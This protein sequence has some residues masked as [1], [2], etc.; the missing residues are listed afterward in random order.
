MTEKRAG[1]AVV[2]GGPAGL[3]AAWRLS[4]LGCGVR[5][6]EA[7]PR[8]G[9][10]LRTEEVAGRGADAVVQLLSDGYTDTRRLVGAMGLADRLMGVAGRDALWRNGRPHALRYGSVTSMVAS[11]A[12]STGLKVRLGLRYMPF[13]ERHAD[14][15]DLNEPARAVEAG[16]DDV[17]IADWG[18]E[19]LGEE[20][21]ETLAYPLLAAYYGVTPEETSAAFFHS[22]AKAGM[23]VEVVGVRGGFGGLAAAMA[24]ALAERG[25]EIRTG[26]PVTAIDA[27]AAGARVVVEEGSVTHDAA[28]LAVPPGV[29]ARLVPAVPLPGGIR[30]RSTATLILSTG[31]RLGTGWF[32]LS[33]PRTEP[34]GDVLAAVCVQGEKET[35]V[36]GGA[37]E[38]L[39][40]VPAPEAGERWA[41]ADAGS[42]VAEGI[43]ALR[44][45]LPAGAD[46]VEEARL[47][48]LPDAVWLPERGH[49]ERLATFRPESLPDRLALAGDYLV[50]PT[51]EGAVRSGLAAAERIAVTAAGA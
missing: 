4:E 39:V 11:G 33:I 16:L 48:R 24:E 27:D 44:R 8:L 40:L 18:L 1:V 38:T 47:V 35:G 9:G 45:V 49:F 17:S 2:G 13:L 14:V 22:L 20:F 51:V 10:R 6:Y 19:H 5:V 28:V 42:V 12:L 7:A 25:G 36:V 41:A 29:A 46:G 15:L 23:G 32:G 50:A 31:R 43:T 26:T 3:A 30:V 37:G 34:P 21:V